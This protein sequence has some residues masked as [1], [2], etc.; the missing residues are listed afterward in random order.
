MLFLGGALRRLLDDEALAAGL[1]VGDVAGLVREELADGGDEG[2]GGG[3]EVGDVAEGVF[4][5]CYCG[6]VGGGFGDW[7][8]GGEGLGAGGWRAGS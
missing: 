6:G 1:P 7:F 3:R 2:W 5:G 8:G 4:P